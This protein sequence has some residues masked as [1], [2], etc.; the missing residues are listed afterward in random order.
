MKDDNAKFITPTWP[1]WMLE[2]QADK[3]LDDNQT[4]LGL[5]ALKF[6]VDE[7]IISETMEHN[8]VIAKVKE[9]FLESL[10]NVFIKIVSGILP[11]SDLKCSYVLDF[12]NNKKANLYMASDVW[13]S[14]AN[15][16]YQYSED[17]ELMIP[18]TRE[19]IRYRCF[20]DSIQ[21]K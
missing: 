4:N 18:A 15:I 13:S 10:V 6:V 19:Y 14:T 7:N 8:A 16:S 2:T 20:L 1:G 5:S 21:P 11:N 17:L 9:P 12:G 3:Q